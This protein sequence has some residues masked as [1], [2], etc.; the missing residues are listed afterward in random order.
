MSK[1]EALITPTGGELR[2]I[3]FSACIQHLTN[4]FPKNDIRLTQPCPTV[5]TLLGIR[6]HL[7]SR[8]VSCAKRVFCCFSQLPRSGVVTVLKRAPWRPRLPL[9]HNCH[10]A[11]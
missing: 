7:V 1:F 6:D 11:L 10:P 8:G 9:S 3:F 2:S 4:P 5:D